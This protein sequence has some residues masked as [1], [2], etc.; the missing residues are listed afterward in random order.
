MSRV[1]LIHLCDDFQLPFGFLGLPHGAYHRDE[2]KNAEDSENSH[3]ERVRRHFVQACG[4]SLVL[5][6]PPVAYYAGC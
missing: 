4:V 3:G 5:G 6:I 2:Q 1:V